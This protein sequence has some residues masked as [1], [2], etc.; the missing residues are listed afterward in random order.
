MQTPAVWC[1]HNEIQH[2]DTQLKQKEKIKRVVR[3]DE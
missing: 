3:I 1:K 2:T